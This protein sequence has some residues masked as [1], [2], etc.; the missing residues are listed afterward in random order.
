MMDGRG[1]SADEEAHSCSSKACRICLLTEDECSSKLISP[2]GCSGT[3]A[4]VHLDCLRK[5]Q[6]SSGSQLRRAVCPVCRQ[7]YTGEGVCFGSDLAGVLRSTYARLATAWALDNLA[8]LVALLL[9]P[10]YLWAD[11][12]KLFEQR[13]FGG[14][15]NLL[16]MVACVLTVA[17]CLPPLIGIRLA[18][19]VDDVGAPHLRLI[20]HGGTVPGLA[21]GA[22]LVSANIDGG[23]FHQSVLVITKHGEWEGTTGCAQLGAQFGAQFSERQSPTPQVHPQPPARRRRGAARRDAAPRPPRRRRRRRRARRRRPRLSR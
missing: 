19:G 17:H 9:L 12:H 11:L 8:L 16:L 5:W 14:A 13:W 1:L 23:I 15:L 2:C 18:L 6:L 21:R 3:S 20:R 4:H 22:L 7:A 10:V